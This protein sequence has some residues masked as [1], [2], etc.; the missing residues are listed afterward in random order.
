L[1]DRDD[2]CLGESGC[3]HASKVTETVN[4]QVAEE[5]GRLHTTCHK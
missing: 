5:R 4:S 3:L 1:E 2:L